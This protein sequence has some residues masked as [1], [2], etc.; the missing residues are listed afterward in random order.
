MVVEVIVKGGKKHKALK[1]LLEV[2]SKEPENK[3][4][5][6]D[7]VR[8][9]VSAGVSYPYSNKIITELTYLGVLNKVGD[10]YAVD[11]EKLKEIIK[12]TK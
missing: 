2:V 9:I 4:S 12:S 1:K 7:L 6:T 11:V 5:W 3:F 10:R 8:I